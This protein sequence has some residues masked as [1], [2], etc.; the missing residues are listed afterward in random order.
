MYHISVIAQTG[1]PFHFYNF[2]VSPCGLQELI[3]ESAFSKFPSVQALGVPYNYTH[4]YSYIK[5]LSPL[6]YIY[7]Y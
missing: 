5:L 4:S 1:L 7:I 6:K 2:Q 3:E